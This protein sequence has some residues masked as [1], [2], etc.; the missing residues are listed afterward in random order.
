M[1]DPDR[2]AAF[3]AMASAA[4]RL[5]DLRRAAT[6]A[7]PGSPAGVAYADMLTTLSDRRVAHTLATGAAPTDIAADGLL[8]LPASLRRRITTLRERGQTALADRLTLVLAESAST[9]R[10]DAPPAR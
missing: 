6:Y 3:V 2:A 9:V 1:S 7:P 10:A 5:I 4:S 8:T